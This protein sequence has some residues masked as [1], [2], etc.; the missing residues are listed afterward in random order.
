MSSLNLLSKLTPASL[1]LFLSLCAAEERTIAVSKRDVH[2]LHHEIL[3]NFDSASYANTARLLQEMKD[4]YPERYAAFPY[5]LLHAK[6]LYRSGNLTSASQIYAALASDRR[7]AQFAL[8]PL[9]RIAVT[10]GFAGRAIAS[11]QSYL[12]NTRYPDYSQ[13]ALEALKYCL[14]QNKAEELLATSQIVMRNSSTRRMAQYHMAKSYRLTK[15]DLLARSLF[16]SLIRTA[17]RDEISSQALTELD[18]IDGHHVRR[19]FNSR[20][21]VGRTRVKQYVLAIAERDERCS[22]LNDVRRRWVVA[23]LRD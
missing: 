2:S 13:V 4:E 11:Y 21:A 3:T 5:A 7:F 6:A 10:Q 20:V 15:D 9:A 14:T 23:G 17:T 22:R 1:L 8:L 18:S 12:R 16:L 19:K